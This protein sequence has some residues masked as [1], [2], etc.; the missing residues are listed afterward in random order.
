M[1][2]RVLFA[3]TCPELLVGFSAPRDAREAEGSLETAP[4]P[5]LPINPD[6]LMR[7]RLSCF[8]GRPKCAAAFLRSFP[9]RAGAFKSMR[10]HIGFGGKVRLRWFIAWS[11]ECC[12]QHIKEFLHMLSPVDRC[13]A[14][15]LSPT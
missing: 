14:V 13:V 9:G 10:S 1:M 15:E 12:G 6:N 4:C 7:P 5:M 11:G 8:H 2:K 3:G